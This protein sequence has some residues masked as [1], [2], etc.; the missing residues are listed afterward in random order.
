MSNINE[1]KNLPE[2][3]LKKMQKEHQ[4]LMDA[5]LKLKIWEAIELKKQERKKNS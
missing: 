4:H 1:F 5:E 3:F 2:K